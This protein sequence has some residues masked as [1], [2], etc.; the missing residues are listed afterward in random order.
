MTKQNDFDTVPQL[1][2]KGKDFS[3]IVP[4]DIDIDLFIEWRDGNLDREWLSKVLGF[5]KK[6]GQFMVISKNNRNYRYIYNLKEIRRVFVV[7]N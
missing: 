7:L 3:H 2:L 1:N 6:D 4:E 5:Q